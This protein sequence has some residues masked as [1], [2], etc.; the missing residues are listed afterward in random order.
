MVNE[1]DVN[2]HLGAYE[3]TVGNPQHETTQSNQKMD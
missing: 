2:D 3:I 1:T